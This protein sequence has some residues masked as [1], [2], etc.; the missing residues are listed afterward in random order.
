MRGSDSRSGSLLTLV[1]LEARVRRD[2]PLRALR[3]FTD[4]ALEALSPEF[5]ALYSARIVNRR[6]RFDPFAPAFAVARRR[7]AEP[8]RSAARS[9][10][11]H[12]RRRLIKLCS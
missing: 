2:H 11:T 1:D 8:L 9:R 3:R 5:S 4:A 7:S 6:Q 10:P 12:P